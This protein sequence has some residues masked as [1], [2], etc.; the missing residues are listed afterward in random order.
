MLAILLLVA[1][2]LSFP[3]LSFWCGSCASSSYRGSALLAFA[4]FLASR[5]GLI[6]AALLF[7]ARLIA[8]V[9]SALHP[10]L[11]EFPIPS[12]PTDSPASLQTEAVGAAETEA[13]GNF[14]R[15]CF[16]PKNNNINPSLASSTSAR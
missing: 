3:S 12:S 2:L 11:F 10:R 4:F 6:A 1:R 9:G 5:S 14:R 7:A 8:A 16:T 15:K 13:S